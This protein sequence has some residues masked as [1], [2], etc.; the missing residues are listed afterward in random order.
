M[1][2]FSCKEVT[3]IYSSFLSLVEVKF[4]WQ[5]EYPLANG[6][7]Q[8]KFLVLKTCLNIPITKRNYRFEAKMVK[9]E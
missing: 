3:V 2:Q 4:V 5:I 6:A 9:T 1:V 7:S 8:G